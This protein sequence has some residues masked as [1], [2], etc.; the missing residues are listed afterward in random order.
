[1]NEADV[2]YK[3][4]TVVSLIHNVEAS[5]TGLYARTFLS[6]SRIGPQK[7]EKKPKKRKEREM[8]M[9]ELRVGDHRSPSRFKVI[10]SIIRK[11]YQ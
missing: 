9:V 11:G 2:V 4:Y 3:L 8:N 10:I 6:M 1:M 5:I 7:E